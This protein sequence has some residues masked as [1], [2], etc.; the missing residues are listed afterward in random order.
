MCSYSDW[1]KGYQLQILSRTE[2]DART[3]AD[4][5]LDLQNDTFDASK[6]NVN[7][8]QAEGTAFPPNPGTDFI[9]GDTRRKPRRRPVADVRFQ[10][11]VAHIHGL[12]NPIPLVDRSGIYPSALSS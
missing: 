3:L 5:I 1:P 9:Y 4:R 12:S 7:Q 11:A 10:Y 8:N 2:N 6:F